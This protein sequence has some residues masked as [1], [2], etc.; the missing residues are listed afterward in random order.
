LYKG[1]LRTNLDLLNQ[2]SDTQIW[3][4]LEKVNMKNKF[5]HKGLEAEVK[6]L[7]EK[8]KSKQFFLD[9]RRWWKSKC[10]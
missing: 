1:T 8:L 10:R 2:Y 7:W 5:L 3:N 9:K 6:C 4:A